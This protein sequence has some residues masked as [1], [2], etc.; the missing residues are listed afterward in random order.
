[1]VDDSSA[2]NAFSIK[3][4]MIPNN[5]HIMFLI[6]SFNIWVI[7]GND[8]CESNKLGKEPKN[9]FIFKEVYLSN[10]S[11]SLC[12]FMAH[13]IVCKDTII[14]KNTD[15]VIKRWLDKLRT[16]PLCFVGDKTDTIHDEVSETWEIVAVK[17]GVKSG[18][19]ITFLD[20]DMKYM[21]KVTYYKNGI[22]VGPNWDLTLG[23]GYNSSYHFVSR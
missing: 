14:T 10:L 6:S 23:R 13:F 3:I 1:M 11:C 19:G 8:F 21:S 18:V 22:N 2:A 17:N 12:S 9:C 15:K 4:K 20:E 5:I 16:S 7:G